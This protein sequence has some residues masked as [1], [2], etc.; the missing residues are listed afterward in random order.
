V[1]ID[2]VLNMNMATQETSAISNEHLYN[3]EEVISSMG[4]QTPKSQLEQTNFNHMMLNQ[5]NEEAINAF[6]SSLRFPDMVVSR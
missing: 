6:I 4:D 1:K 2:V 5:Q 3:H